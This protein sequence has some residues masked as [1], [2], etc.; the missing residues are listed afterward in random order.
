MAAKTPTG[1]TPVRKLYKSRRDK[2][3]DGV[4][5]GLAEYLGVEATGVRILWALLFLFGG[6]GLV[7]YLVAMVLIP[8]NPA[9]QGLKADQR[10]R[11]GSGF[12]WGL[13]LI[14]VGGLILLHDASYWHYRF[15]PWQFHGFGFVRFWS[16]VFPILLVVIGIACVTGVFHGKNGFAAGGS[17]T[18]GKKLTRS[19][20]DRKIGGICGGLGAYFEVDSTLIRVAAVLLALTH[21]FGMTAL[22][23][24]L[25]IVMPVD[26]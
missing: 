15:F 8:P 17:R 7:A 26:K 13:L 4:C 22:Y 5:A 11:H 21:F 20:T 1:K 9:H 6:V 14:L 10:V 12:I 3:I 23:L 18:A 24:V 19:S 25:L 16:L 2:I